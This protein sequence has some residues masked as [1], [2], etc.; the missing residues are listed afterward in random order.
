MSGPQKF[1]HPQKVTFLRNNSDLSCIPHNIVKMF[2]L[3][4]VSGNEAVDQERRRN[5]EAEMDMQPKTGAKGLRGVKTKSY[6]KTGCIRSQKSKNTLQQWLVKPSKKAS[7]GETCDA[8]EDPNTSNA[9]DFQST[10]DQSMDYQKSAISDSDEDTQVMTQELDEY[11][12]REQQEMESNPVSSGASAMQ[13]AKITDFFTGNTSA[14]S[15]VKLSRPQK[16][17]VDMETNQ[18]S[19][20]TNVKWLGTSISEL[21][22]RPECGGPLPRL[23]NIPGM[24]TVMIR[25]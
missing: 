20:K 15:P 14:S 21:K 1:R 17:D 12:S 11:C 8:S 19:D 10:S 9:C 7:T 22:R 5:T 16:E 2:S 3:F 13:N 25:V 6:Q 18:D 24:H 23:K 4:S